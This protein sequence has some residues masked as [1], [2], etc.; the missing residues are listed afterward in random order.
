VQVSSPMALVPGLSVVFPVTLFCMQ[1]ALV[2]ESVVGFDPGRASGITG[3]LPLGDMAS[4]FSAHQLQT[5][6]P[7]LGPHPS[8]LWPRGP[9]KAHLVA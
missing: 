9:S 7:L 1:S 2:N 4:L 6:L 3:N 5:P 8:N